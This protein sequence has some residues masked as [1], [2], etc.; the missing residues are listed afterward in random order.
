[1]VVEVAVHLSHSFENA[2]PDVENGVLL[3]RV[4]DCQAYEALDGFELTFVIFCD[5]LEV[6]LVDE[7]KDA[8]GLHAVDLIE[9]DDCFLVGHLRV[10][11]RDFS[12]EGLLNLVSG[13]VVLL[14][15]EHW[16]NHEASYVF[17]I[18]LVIDIALE[19]LGLG[20]AICNDCRFG[21]VADTTDSNVIREGDPPGFSVLIQ[22]QLYIFLILLREH[23]VPIHSSFSI[24]FLDPLLLLIFRQLIHRKDQIRL[25]ISEHDSNFL[26]AKEPRQKLLNVPD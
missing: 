4:V 12:V 2:K 23:M 10:C 16:S 20:H 1:M 11:I 18:C 21:G 8:Q 14:V 13:E 9:F 7:L 22:Q 19:L 17:D 24:F 15:S 25:D 26:K 6:L 3:G 5:V